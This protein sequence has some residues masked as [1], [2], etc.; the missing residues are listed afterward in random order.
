MVHPSLILENLWGELFT[1]AKN[2]EEVMHALAI[3]Q[4]S[5]SNPKSSRILSMASHQRM[6][7]ALVKSI[8]MYLL[9]QVFL[10]L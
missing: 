4:K 7:N 2:D 3:S 5:S 9:L 6:L 10:Q 8:T 1:N